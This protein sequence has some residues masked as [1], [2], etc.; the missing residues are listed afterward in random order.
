MNSKGI[1]KHRDLLETNIVNSSKIKVIFACSQLR[2][3]LTVKK[4]SLS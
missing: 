2:Q 3:D 4:P 1:K